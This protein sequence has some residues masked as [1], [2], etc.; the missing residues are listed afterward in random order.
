MAAETEAQG[1]GKRRR[2]DDAV[3][4][5]AAEAGAGDGPLVAPTDAAWAVGDRA[6]AVCPLCLG[7][8]QA[9]GPAAGAAGDSCQQL[10]RCS[11]QLVTT[12]SSLNDPQ[13]HAVPAFG[14]TPGVE[15]TPVAAAEDGQGQG[16]AH[17]SGTVGAP[18]APVVTQRASPV[19]SLAA[20]AATIA[21]EYEFDSFA[22]EVSLPASLA[23][24]QQALSWRLRQGG[25]FQE[26]AAAL[27]GALGEAGFGRAST[28]RTPC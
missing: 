27:A 6:A 9:A 24:R 1:G 8:L 13:R 18:L 17:D 5:P 4:A 28:A 19:P 20:A 3:G 23:V 25:G 26:R 22:L 11:L 10:L 2:L 16:R 12:I 15:A 21:A 7:L 14:T